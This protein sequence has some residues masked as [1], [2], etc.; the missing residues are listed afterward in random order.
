MTWCTYLQSFEKIQQC[1]F[2]LQCE[3]FSKKY[4]FYTKLKQHPINI[5]QSNQ[6]AHPHHMVQIPAKFREN[7]AMRFRD[8]AKTKRDG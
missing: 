1:V 2:E 7:T 3:N 6:S 8:S 4:F 5:N